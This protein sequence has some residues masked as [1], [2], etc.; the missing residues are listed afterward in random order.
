MAARFDDPF[1]PDD[2]AEEDAT[3][4]TGRNQRLT[5]MPLPQEE[6]EYF[7]PV[8]ENLLASYQSE[9]AA[10]QHVN[11]YELP[12]MPEVADCI[13][14]CRTLLF[15]GFVGNSLT[16]ASETDLQNYV[17]NRVAGLATSLRVQIYRGVHHRIE[18]GRDGSALD[19]PHCSRKSEEITQHFLE[20]LPALRRTLALDVDAFFQGDPAAS[21]TDEIIFC[22]P[23]M[24][25]ITV[26]RMA[27]ALHQLGAGLIPRMMTEIAHERVGID[28]HPA[29]TIGDSFFIDHGTGVVIGAT[30]VIGSRVRIYQGVTLGALSVAGR[31]TAGK[32][33]PTLEDDVI[34]YSGATVLGGETVIGAQAVVGGNCW[35]TTSVPPGAVVTQDGGVR[36]RSPPA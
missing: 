31:Q 10:I 23:G 35:V 19:C 25:A 36:L 3:V 11:S 29:A 30:T 26:Y 24:Y 4:T 5:R 32:R 2:F 8:A 12:S 27:H 15:P 13:E 14:K 21:G 28:I 9:S 1:A 17:R 18:Q 16:Q 7:A 33:H 22:Y 6:R 34:V 20:G